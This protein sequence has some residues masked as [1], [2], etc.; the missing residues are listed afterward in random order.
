M[1]GAFV[2]SFC[3]DLCATFFL[4]PGAQYQELRR[5]DTGQ[6]V[7]HTSRSPIS[8]NSYQPAVR[9]FSFEKERNLEVRKCHRHQVGLRRFLRVLNKARASDGSVFVKACARGEHENIEG[10][11]LSLPCAPASQAPDFPTSLVKPP[12]SHASPGPEN[13]HHNVTKQWTSAT[14]QVSSKNGARLLRDESKD[15]ITNTCWLGS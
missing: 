13:Q 6:C 10:T 4:L 8:Q 7:D 3:L 11:I 9:K 14:N 1:H 12:K 15:P 2:I 5:V